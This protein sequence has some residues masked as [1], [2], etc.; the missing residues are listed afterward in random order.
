MYLMIKG[1][2]FLSYFV[3]VHGFAVTGDSVITRPL[4]RSKLHSSRC[5]YFIQNLV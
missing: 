4:P 5:T 1:E 2:L 3:T